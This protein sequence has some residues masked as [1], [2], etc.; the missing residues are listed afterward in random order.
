MIHTPASRQ[1]QLLCLMAQ[2]PADLGTLGFEMAEA[3]ANTGTP[4]LAQFAR[5]LSTDRTG[6]TCGRTLI[7]SDRQQ[8]IAA[9]ADLGAGRFSYTLHAADPLPVAFLFPAQGSEHLHM[10]AGLYNAEPAFRQRVDACC[11]L[12][13]PHLGLDLRRVL[14]PPP[15]EAE[16]AAESLARAAIA[17][18][19]LFVVEWALAHLWMSWGIRPKALIGHSVG[20]YVAAC[21]SGVFSLEDALR[22]VAVRGR[23]SDDLP[24]G[25]MLAVALS[26]KEARACTSERLAL[27][28]VNSPHYCTVAGFE[29]DIEALEGT[30]EE[31]QVSYHR[32]P[33]RR[34]FH[35]RLVKDILKPFRREVRKAELEAPK[36]PLLSNVTGG[37]M[38]ERESTDMDYW[39]G[40]LR[41]TVRFSRNV[42]TLLAD[43]PVVF[44]EVGPGRTLTGFVEDHEAHDITGADS[45]R[46]FS[47]LPVSPSPASDQRSVL[48]AL[49]QL[50]LAGVEIDW[51]AFHGQ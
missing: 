27:A 35:S 48:D 28:A 40:H 15:E 17:Q 31:R 19:A 8:A 44:L 22:L 16:D 14:Y 38:H 7:V 26:E 9:L 1:S 47:T 20:E 29:D 24:K 18:P 46:V 25:A 23:L 51:P 30:M 12:L 39:V 50:W 21:L 5:D 10:A 34:A 13:E 11:D 37:W 32:I 33:T 45:V 6:M 3:L 42:E 49:G 43:G 2:S 41:E 36:V 4:D